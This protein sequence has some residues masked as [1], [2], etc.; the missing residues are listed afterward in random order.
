M[1]SILSVR[2][3]VAIAFVHFSS[4]THPEVRISNGTLV[5]YSEGHIDSFFGIPYALPPIHDRRLRPPQ[6][7]DHSFGRLKLPK[8]NSD[9]QAC[10]QMTLTPVN[11]TATTDI[12]KDQQGPYY[13][14]NTGFHVLGEEDCLTIN[15][16]RPTNASP[17]KKLPVLVWI[18]GGALEV[19]AT[20]DGS[21]LVN[22]SISMGEPM[23]FVAVNYRL[24]A[25]GFLQGKELSDAGATNIGLRD[26]RK[27]LEWVAENIGAFGGDPDRVTIWVS[28]D[29][30]PHS[31]LS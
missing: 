2:A 27:G 25:F 26:Q 24:N 21:V 18:Y 9:V 13:G 8:S 14:P 15:V 17:G 7:I 12:P 23:I 5:G 29:Y 20:S 22:Q 1:P 6:A 11:L 4:A 19:G 16:Q 3:L 10:T 31:M 30:V 28:M